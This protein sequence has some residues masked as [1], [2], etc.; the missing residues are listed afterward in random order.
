[1]TLATP[2]GP[3]L[4]VFTLAVSEGA[5]RQRVETFRKAIAD[6]TSSGRKALPAQ[7]RELYD[8]LVRPAESRLAQAKRLMIIPDGP[9]HVLPFAALMRNEREYLVEWK[10]LHSIVSAAVYAELR[11]PHPRA[12]R[13]VNQVVAFGDPRYPNLDKTKPESVTDSELRSAVTNGLALTRLV[14]SREEVETI[15]ATFPERTK[16]YVGA[17]ATEERAKSLGADVRY[18]HFAAHGLLDERFPLNSALAL[19]IPEKWTEGHKNGLLQAWEIFDQVRLDAD[20]V[21]LSACN[22][23][24]GQEQ[25]GEGL[26]GLSRAFLYAGARSVLASLWNVNDYRTATLMKRFYADLKQGKSKDEA[27]RTA[28]VQLLHSRASSH[29]FYWAAFTLIGDWK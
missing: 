13:A 19:T 20:L 10:S 8:L 26:I 27:L 1:M 17:D 3:G 11:K 2:T 16:S 7:A 15:A 5:L 4:S 25:N 18:V 14:F 28:Q 24:L 12:H 29:P 9:L 23:A 6:T 22:T 21:T